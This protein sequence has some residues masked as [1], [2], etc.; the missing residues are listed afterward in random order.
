MTLCGAEVNFRGHR[1]VLAHDQMGHLVLTASMAET[2]LEGTF[3][4]RVSPILSDGLGNPY[5]QFYS[6]LSHMYS[7]AVSLLVGDVMTGF[8]LCTVF[9]LALAFVYAFKLGRYL[10]LSSH[11]AAV[12]A[13]LFV[14][15]PYLSTDRV[16][17]G[18]FAEYVAFC[19]L[20]MAL[21]YNLRALP[22][23]SFKFWALAALS[24][25]ALLLAHLITG[26]FFLFFYAVFFILSGLSLLARRYVSRGGVGVGAPSRIRPFLR[27]S[28]AAA[29]ICLFATLLGLYCL[30]PAIFYG[31]LIMKRQEL[32]G[33]SSAA[34]G[35]M[36]PILSLFSLTDTSWDYESS[37]M[38]HARFQTGFALLA[39]FG[40]FVYLLARWR[41]SW[42]F[43][44]ALTAGLVL[45][46]VARPAVFL[47]PPLKYVD[48]A[49]FSY[50]F[51]SLFTLS[52]ACSGALALRAVFRASPG[53]T[54]ATRT[55]AAMAIIAISV[56]LGV[57]YVYP[58]PVQQGRLGLN[59]NSSIL[60][61]NSRLFDG[62]NAYL[63]VPPPDGSDDWVAPESVSVRWR[64]KPGDWT[65][66]ADLNEYYSMSGG[67]PGEVLLDVLYYPGLQDIEIRVDG[68]PV[69]AF[70]DTWWQ[71][72]D[73]VRGAFY[74]EIGGFHGLKISGA[75]EKGILEAR[76]RFIGYKWA[77]WISLSAFAFLLG[78]FMFSAWRTRCKKVRGTVAASSGTDVGRLPQ[79][80]GA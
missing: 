12:A 34:S 46:T 9:I 5:H 49:Q 56:A 38:I 21:Y 43:P 10:T 68:K 62:E 57:P 2:F 45:V 32:A 1:D 30:G 22:L 64:G 3:P 53:F 67:Q 15:A 51:L 78:G 65:F 75:P 77:N 47:Y 24:T 39:S 23:N 37:F 79:E 55:A 17:R 26:F 60:Y 44:F 7:A 31:D 52:A 18:A 40:A 59:L 29:T 19:L 28:F 63:R 66:R 14:T 50:R 42:A 4:P 13:F 35:Y 61:D 48:I 8:S 33:V 36:T 71:R 76:V 58:K 16:L 74:N 69:G 80:P 20:P 73:S 11:C 54:P 6:P 70:L 41:T 25:A 72:R 27:K